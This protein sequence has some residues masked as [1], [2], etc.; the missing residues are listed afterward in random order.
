MKPAP[1]PARRA[2]FS[3]AAS[4]GVISTAGLNL[5][6]QLPEVP[7][8]TVLTSPPSTSG[9]GESAGPTDQQ[10]KQMILGRW[11]IESHGVRIIENREDGTASMDLTFDFLSSLLYGQKMTLELTWTVD[12]EALAYTIQSGQPKSNVDRL[13]ADYGREATYNIRSI[14]DRA[15]HLVRIPD[16]GGS[17][18]W[19]RVD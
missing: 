10:L 11:R 6:P 5:G 9:G 16:K 19:T 7:Q 18:V 4:L 1:V 3:L 12:G 13:V 2:G 17:D 8:S 15:M 14:S